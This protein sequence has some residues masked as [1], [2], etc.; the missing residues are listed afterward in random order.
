[1]IGSA[2]SPTLTPQRVGHP[3]KKPTPQSASPRWHHRGEKEA[4]HGPPATL[5]DAPHHDPRL[6][7]QQTAQVQREG[8]PFGGLPSTTLPSTHSAR[9]GQ[10][11][12]A[13]CPKLY[14]GAASWGQAAPS[15]S[16]R[17]VVTR[18]SV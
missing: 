5:Q 4:K 14:R 6:S 17:R 3:R 15:K 12:Q 7:Q 18:R 8:V 1:M 13:G 9:S 16:C 2:S 11:G 10:A